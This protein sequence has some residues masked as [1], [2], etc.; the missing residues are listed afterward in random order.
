MMIQSHPE[1]TE[2]PL[3][4]PVQHVIGV[5]VRKR[6]VARVFPSAANASNPGN[7]AHMRNRHLL[8]KC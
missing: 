7:A 2:V 1:E 6:D 8:Y 5:D 3:A 4:M